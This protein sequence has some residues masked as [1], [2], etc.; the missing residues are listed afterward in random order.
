MT[1]VKDKSAIQR[2]I[3]QEKGVGAVQSASEICRCVGPVESADILNSESPPQLAVVKSTAVV[4]SE[5]GSA[6]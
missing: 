3:H 5:R 4:F 1:S 2:C 6:V